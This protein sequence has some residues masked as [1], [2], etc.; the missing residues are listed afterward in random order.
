MTQESYDLS[1]RKTILDRYNDFCTRQEGQHFLWYSISFITLVGSVMPIS[2]ILMSMTPLFLPY[3]FVDMLFFFGNVLTII[4]RARM[5][6]VIS[7][8]LLT[9]AVNIL[10]PAMYFFVVQIVG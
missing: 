7:F 10:V 6:V 5:K 1:Q 3:V 2:L 4:G 9:V 8:F